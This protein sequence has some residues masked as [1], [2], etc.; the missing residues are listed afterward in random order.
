M[1]MGGDYQQ[2]KLRWR[3]V[4]WVYAVSWARVWRGRENS[5]GEV[6][7]GPVM[8]KNRPCSFFWSCG[9][10]R[11]SCDPGN[12]CSGSRSSFCG[13][14]G[15]DEGSAVTRQLSSAATST[16]A[17]RS[18]D[19]APRSHSI[20]RGQRAVGRREVKQRR[21]DG[22]TTK[23]RRNVQCKYDV[24]DAGWFFGRWVDIFTGG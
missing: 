20:V 23:P 7:D 1:L 9:R 13:S 19:R 6:S 21:R 8:C 14:S 3:G 16:G 2:S 15:E 11:G 17:S 5:V 22:E 4:G 12:S 18:L 24:V 10:S